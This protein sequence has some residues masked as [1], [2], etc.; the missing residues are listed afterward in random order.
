VNDF[1]I[2]LP[3]R[4]ISFRLFILKKFFFFLY[5]KI[6]SKFCCDNSNKDCIIS[7]MKSGKAPTAVYNKDDNTI[8]RICPDNIETEECECNEDMKEG[9][10]NPYVMNMRRAMCEARRNQKDKFVRPNIVDL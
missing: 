7:D 5:N 2:T 1:D 6:M 9:S 4:C 8:Y 3:K 10:M